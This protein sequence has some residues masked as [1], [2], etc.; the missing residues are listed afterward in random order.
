LLR[1][2]LPQVL[3]TIR[4]ERQLTERLQYN[5]L[6]RWFVGLGLD[7]L[8]WD[9]TVFTVLKAAVVIVLTGAV[10]TAASAQQRP[11]ASTPLVFEGVTVVDVERANLLSAQQVLIVGNHIQAVGSANSVP[12]PKNAQVVD[13]PANI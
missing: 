3:Y 1:A 13:T 2:R 6:C 12:V 8:I 10:S 9:V 5:L 4:S 11:S 7:D